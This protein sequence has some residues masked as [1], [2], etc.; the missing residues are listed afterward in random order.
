MKVESAQTI[1][2]D[3]F[4]AGDIQQ[5]KQVCREWCM[6]VGACVTVEPVDY[7]YTG[8]EER[9]IRVGFIN[10]PRFPSDVDTMF[11][12]ASELADK[13]MHRLC[14]HSYSI[15]GPDRTAWVSRRKDSA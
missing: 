14:Q 9:G 12:R 11:N 1:G 10:Y 4:I 15:V 7:I 8:G 13:L 2:M 3:I 6:E 5:A